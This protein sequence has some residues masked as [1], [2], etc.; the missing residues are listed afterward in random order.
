[1]R[2]SVGFVLILVAQAVSGFA[3]R[4]GWSKSHVKSDYTIN[5]ILGDTT[6]QYDSS[7]IGINHIVL[8]SNNHPATFADVV[9]TLPPCDSPGAM[10]AGPGCGYCGTMDCTCSVIP[11]SNIL[12]KDFVKDSLFA[13]PI[14][15]M[16]EAGNRN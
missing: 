6:A 12:S 8:S 11:V 1:M 10:A 9:S 7:K 15:L 2:A 3:T 4:A 14:E 13:S 5:K 16:M